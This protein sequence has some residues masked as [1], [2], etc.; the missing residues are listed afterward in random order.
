MLIKGIVVDMYVLR[1]IK[2]FDEE[3]FLSCAKDYDAIL[4]LEDGMKSGSMAEYLQGLVLRKSAGAKSCPRTDII[5]FPDK[6]ISNGTRSQI[7][8]E[9]GLSGGQIAERAVRALV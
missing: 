8:E 5:T 4:F 1:F 7:L 2:P 3:H 6:F 9:A